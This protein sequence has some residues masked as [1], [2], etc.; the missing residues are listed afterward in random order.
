MLQQAGSRP[1]LEPKSIRNRGDWVDAAR[2]VFQMMDHI[3]LRTFDPALIEI[4]R[5]D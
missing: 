1:M 3:H 2:E 5:K 4:A